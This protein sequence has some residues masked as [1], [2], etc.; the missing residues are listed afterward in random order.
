MAKIYV[1]TIPILDR[2]Q[3]SLESS[4]ASSGRRMPRMELSGKRLLAITF[5]PGGAEC[6]NRTGVEEMNETKKLTIQ[7]EGKKSTQVMGIVE[8]TQARKKDSKNTPNVARK[9]YKQGL[10]RLRQQIDDGI[11]P[12][13]LQFLTD[14]RRGEQDQGGQPPQSG[15]SGGGSIPSPVRKRSCSSQVDS[16]SKRTK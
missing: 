15:G 1:D 11:Q 12:R 10:R 9:V 13:I 14:D 6:V 16:P 4:L 3:K 7:E 5:I 2:K 8:G